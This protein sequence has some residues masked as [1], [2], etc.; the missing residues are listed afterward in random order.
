MAKTIIIKLKKA[1]RRATVF[2]I[3]DDRGNILAT[4]VPKSQ[5]ISGMTFSV[6][7]SVRVVILTSSCSGSG[8][9]IGVTNSSCGS[10]W[11]IPVTTITKPELAAIKFQEVNTASIWR[12]LTNPVIYNTYYGC[13]KPYIIEY[14]FAY[15]YQDEILQ[16]VKDYTKAFTYLPTDDGVF[17]DN[18][19]ISINGYFNKA[20][21]YNDQQS[22]GVLEL[23]AKPMNNLKEYLKYP[24]YNTDSKTITYT[25]S[26]NFYQYNTF[27]GLVKDKSLPL[28]TKT[29]ESM[30]IDKIVNQANMDY[31]KRSFKKEPLRAKDLKVRHILDNKSDVHLTSQFIVTPSQISYK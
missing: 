28:F 20:V 25:K 26:D 13:I 12:H 17:N 19:K 9:N 11:N 23:V 22:T 2:S 31:S 16:N 8:S 15:Q 30:S 4:N 10:T 3:S 24:V 1:G 6:D 27:W 29:C 18:R 5:L 7:D 21:L 14:P